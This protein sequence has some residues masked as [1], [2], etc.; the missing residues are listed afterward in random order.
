MAK[1]CVQHTV[2]SKK[3]KSQPRLNAK[4][5]FKQAIAFLENYL[6]CCKLC[7]KSICV[8]NCVLQ[9]LKHFLFKNAFCIKSTLGITFF[10]VNYVLCRPFEFLIISKLGMT[11]Y[12]LNTILY[13]KLPFTASQPFLVI[14]T[15][16]SLQNAF[17]VTSSVLHHFE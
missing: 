9:K 17:V 8:I 4:R 3:S 13:G 6:R 16:S 1:R 5:I 7:F 12:A 2:Y 14:T 10:N 11:F 15:K